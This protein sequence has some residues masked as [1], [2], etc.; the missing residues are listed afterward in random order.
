MKFHFRF[1]NS[2]IILLFCAVTI[3]N[4]KK[5]KPKRP[6]K[7]DNKATYIATEPVISR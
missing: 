6:N 7:T 4:P 1:H 2:I 5:I 3:P